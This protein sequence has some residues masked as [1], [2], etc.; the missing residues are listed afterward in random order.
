VDR[1]VEAHEQLIA[2]ETLAVSVRTEQVDGGIDVD[3]SSP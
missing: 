3:P 2:N 1:A